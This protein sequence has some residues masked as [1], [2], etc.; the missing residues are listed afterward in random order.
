MLIIVFPT[1]NRAEIV[2]WIYK[3]YGCIFCYCPCWVSIQAEA[4]EDHPVQ[5]TLISIT[6]N[7]ITFAEGRSDRESRLKAKK[8]SIGVRKKNLFP[9]LSM[10]HYYMVML[11]ICVWKIMQLPSLGEYNAENSMWPAA[12]FI[13][14]GSS[15]RSV[16]KDRKEV[17]K[18]SKNSFK[19]QSSVESTY[20]DS[21]GFTWVK[22]SISWFLPKAKNMVISFD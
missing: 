19:N 16:Q 18:K 21:L 10:S 5:S 12:C 4:T 22:Q 7:S 15:Y 1:H 2:K 9:H 20:I 3:E 11:P 6:Q 17:T 13:H 8:V 14:V